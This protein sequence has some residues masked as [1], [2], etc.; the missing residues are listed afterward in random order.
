MQWEQQFSA[1][2]FFFFC[3]SSEKK[4]CNIPQETVIIRFF[5]RCQ[6]SFSSTLYCQFKEAKFFHQICIRI[7]YIKL[8]K[9]AQQ[10]TADNLRNTCTCWTTF[11]KHQWECE[12][13]ALKKSWRRQNN[14]CNLYKHLPQS[15][16]QTQQQQLG[17]VMQKENN[18]NEQKSKRWLQKNTETLRARLLAQAGFTRL[19]FCNCLW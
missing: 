5:L 3:N 6:I 19:P 13:Q 8:Q 12:M 17:L 14:F 2:W 16:K 1:S 18:C 7:L 15:K 9:V 4:S 11:L 10:A